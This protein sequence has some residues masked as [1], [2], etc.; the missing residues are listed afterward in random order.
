ML[1]RCVFGNPA[2]PYRALFEWAGIDAAD[3]AAELESHGLDA[4][5]AR[6]HDAGVRVTLDEFKGLRPIERPGPRQSGSPGPSRAGAR[7]RSNGSSTCSPPAR[8]STGCP[9]GS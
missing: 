3:V 4:T 2:S 1:E 8:G 6:L 7:S 5:L 9:R